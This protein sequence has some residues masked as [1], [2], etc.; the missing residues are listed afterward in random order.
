MRSLKFLTWVSWGYLSSKEE[1]WKPQ[2]QCFLPFI[3]CCYLFSNW[4]IYFF[5]L[6]FSDPILFYLFLFLCST[7]C[8]LLLCTFFSLSFFAYLLLFLSSSVSFFVSLLLSF[9]LASIFL[10]WRS[11]IMICFSSLLLF[12]FCLLLS[13]YFA[14]SSIDFPIC[15][16]S[17]FSIYNCS[18]SSHFLNFSRTSWATCCTFEIMVLLWVN[19]SWLF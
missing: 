14:L 5:I 2:L 7:F 17:A 9:L 12:L 15:P 11:L 3:L 13:F 4:N 8:C 18:R 16:S 6:V 1:S 19:F 10:L